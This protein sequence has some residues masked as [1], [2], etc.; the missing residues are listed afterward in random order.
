MLTWVYAGI[1]KPVARKFLEPRAR[2]ITQGE[3]AGFRFSARDV[4]GAFAAGTYEPPIQRALARCLKPGDVFYD[5]GAN[6]GFFSIL[7]ATLTGSGGAV[8]AFEPVPDNVASIHRNVRLNGLTNVKVHAVAV[9]ATSGREELVLAR[10]RGG[11]SLASAGVHVPDPAATMPVRT[12]AIDE[13]IQRP[14]TAPPTLVKIDVEGAELGVLQGMQRT[15]RAHRPVVLYE[16]DD[17]DEMTM[18]RR[19][20]QLDE[21]VAAN[22]YRIERLQHAYPA[23]G[24]PVG[25][26]L[27][28][29]SEINLT[30]GNY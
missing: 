1:V 18:H 23:G 5:I 27:A 26:T 15:M 10:N 30:R 17:A 2:T 13:F 9:A 20:T 25:H 16:V 3:G 14:N 29:P 8:Y 19:W 12:V 21:F 6:V 24:W 11:A 22:G 4:N 7:A 28:A